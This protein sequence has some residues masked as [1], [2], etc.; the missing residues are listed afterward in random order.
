VASRVLK[1]LDARHSAL[2]SAATEY[3]SPSVPVV[4][5]D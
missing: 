2:A 1:C 3:A 5:D 4:A